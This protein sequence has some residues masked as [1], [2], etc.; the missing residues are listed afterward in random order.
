MQPG[1]LIKQYVRNGSHEIKRGKTECFS[2][3][4]TLLQKISPR[5]FIY[6]QQQNGHMTYL[7]LYQYRMHIFTHR[8]L[9]S[10]EK[11]LSEHPFP[12]ELDTIA[13]KLQYYRYKNGLLQKDMASA[14]EIDRATY[15]SY[16]DT[17]RDLYSLDI[18]EKS[19]KL[20]QI[21]VEDLL[22]DYH[23]FL[24]HG[25]GEQLKSLRKSCKLTQNDLSRLLLVQRNTVNKWETEKTC[26]SRSTY[27]KLFHLNFLQQHTLDKF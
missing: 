15:A 9:S 27:E 18:L 19:A 25:Q 5:F 10:A 8:S 24:Y 3:N 2:E 20:F 12:E 11:Y 16:E 23:A 22:D 6:C 21:P 4:W 7:S 14:L 1:V 13:E 17:S 26:L